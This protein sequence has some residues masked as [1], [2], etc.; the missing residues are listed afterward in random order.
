M[1]LHPAVFPNTLH[2]F[3]VNVGGGLVIVYQLDPY[4]RWIV[5]VCLVLGGGKFDDL[6]REV[7][8]KADERWIVNHFEDDD[9][10][11]FG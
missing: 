2:E 10:E 3:K 8:G 4:E 5:H 9:F 11:G 7:V 1:G 6:F